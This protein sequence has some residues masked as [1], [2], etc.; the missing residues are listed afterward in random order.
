MALRSCNVILYQTGK[1]GSCCNTSIHSL[2]AT[3]TFGSKIVTLGV[4]SS[5]LYVKSSFL[6]FSPSKYLCSNSLLLNFLIS[7]SNCLEYVVEFELGINL[8][9]LDNRLNSDS[10]RV[11]SLRLITGMLRFLVS[12]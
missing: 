4:Q 8:S 12:P 10:E 6:S 1:G 2:K 5:L 9:P 7:S 3:N 11:W